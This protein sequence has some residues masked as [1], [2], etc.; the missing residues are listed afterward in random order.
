VSFLP[1]AFLCM[2]LDFH[3][4]H[5]FNKVF[6]HVYRGVALDVL[7]RW[8]EEAVESFWKLCLLPKALDKIRDHLEKGH[9]VVLISGG[10][11]PMLKPL[12]Q[13]LGV[14]ALVGAK[15]ELHLGRLTGHLVGGALSGRAKSTAV[16]ETAARLGVSLSR[17]YA[18]ADSIGDREFL[19]TVKFPR[20]VNP[21]RRLR[22]LALDREWPI[23]SWR[24][25]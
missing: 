6:Y 16:R 19:E 4:R 9:Q 14:H 23:I 22:R 2:L 17:S 7:D 20:A 24:R 3:D 1:R 15:P 25:S 11:E 13:S 10:L 8:A 5:N 18:Y 21:D 12:A